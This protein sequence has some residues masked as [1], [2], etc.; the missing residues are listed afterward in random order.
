[1]IRRNSDGRDDDSG[2]NN[3]NNNNNNNGNNEQPRRA[4]S[5]LH[6]RLLNQQR[7]NI[8]LQ[9]L[10]HHMLN[11]RRRREEEEALASSPPPLPD[12]DMPILSHHEAET[13]NAMCRFCFEGSVEQEQE[14]AEDTGKDR[15]ALVAPCNCDGGSRWVH[16]E[17]LR[18][19]QR[20]QTRSL[21]SSNV[22]AN[23]TTYTSAGYICNV[24]NS[25]YLSRPPAVRSVRRNLLKRG[26]L[27]VSRP[28]TLGRTF[29][30]TVVLLLTDVC[31]SP[32][33]AFGLIVNS[34]LQ[35]EPQNLVL[36]TPPSS[37][38]LHQSSINESSS[39]T[40]QNSNNN[41][42]NNNNAI[43]EWRRGGP[44]CGGRLGVV[45]YTVLHTYPPTI[46]PDDE[47]VLDVDIDEE[48][49]EE[50]ETYDDN[51]D[52]VAD[53][54]D[55]EQDLEAGLTEMALQEVDEQS[56]R[57]E[58]ETVDDDDEE[59]DDIDDLGENDDSLC[60]PMSLPV[61]DITDADTISRPLQF[62][63][64]PE[65]STPCTFSEDN[66]G[67]TVQRIVLDGQEELPDH[68]DTTTTSSNNNNDTA[69]A[70]HK[71]IVFSGYCKWRAG[72][73]ER[74]IQR[75]VWDVCIDATPEDILRHHDSGFWEEISESNRLLSWQRLIEEEGG[76]E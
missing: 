71:V 51:E 59:V 20:M 30:N 74:E 27:L 33:G 37:P 40:E 61:F 70:P 8:L 53:S 38:P 41:N 10:F 76:D 1:M 39:P 58:N 17:C 60:A 22:N 23:T 73:L 64:S 72:Q 12:R 56:A 46:H 26:T 43:I 19:W 67:N 57:D 63:A 68:D 15:N 48:Y 45:H 54:D 42:N 9:V 35:Q 6:N 16:L 52:A 3:N 13:T 4:P 34:P 49:F 25:P 44:V 2:D 7:S 31:G 65:T 55:D 36:S 50:N 28:N 29:Q 32:Q 14:Q 5:A 75:E 66:L 69:Q 18:Q 21:S 62:V 24:C 11:S 47:D